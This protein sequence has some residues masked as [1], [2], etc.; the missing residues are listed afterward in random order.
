VLFESPGWV[1]AAL[2][3]LALHEW[4]GVSAV[5][6]AALVAAWVAKDLVIYPWVRDAYTGRGR[7]PKE[8]LIDSTGV[9]VK[10]LRP[11]GIVRL[12]SELWRAEPAAGR[13]EIPSGRRVRVEEVRGLTLVVA[14]MRLGLPPG[15]D[16]RQRDEA[17]EHHG[18]DEEHAEGREGRL[19]P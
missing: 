6:L 16:S 1:L 19:D 18:E 3:A 12:G 11:L 4:A 13:E 15:Q 17:Q 14:E 2:V 5:L 10:P 9:V 8:S 7:T